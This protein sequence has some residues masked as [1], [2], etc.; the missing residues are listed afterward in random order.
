[1]PDSEPA[2][3]T[4]DVGMDASERPSWACQL[5]SPPR[6]SQSWMKAD[7]GYTTCSGCLNRLRSAVAEV[8][9]GYYRLDAGL[10]GT[11]DRGSRGAPGFHSVPPANLS[12][13]TMRDP[14]SLP[15]ETPH[16]LTQYLW[17]PLADLTLEPGQYGPPAGAYV[18]K[19]EV[20]VGSDGRT[21]TE[22]SRAPLSVPGTLAGICASIAEMREV[23]GPLSRSVGELCRW[24]DNHLDWLTRQDWVAEVATEIHRLAAQI[25]GVHEPRRKIGP[26][27]NTL[28]EGA[29]T[30][31]CG[32]TLYAPL[33]GDRVSCV[34]CGRAWDR[35][36]WLKLGELVRAA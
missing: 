33:R 32:V 20:W 17:D 26:C 21:H 15:Y 31:Q 14:R 5:H 12:V 23:A 11:A 9:T 2:S 3:E 35:D 36:D 10:S 1:M 19:R 34:G 25:R 22:Q 29:T 30:R 24:L 8:R 18:E 28:D 13:V 4:F 16:D 27:P 7:D 6:A